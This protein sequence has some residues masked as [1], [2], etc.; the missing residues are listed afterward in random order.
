M[1]AC[2]ALVLRSPQFEFLMGHIA[3]AAPSFHRCIVFPLCGRN[4]V[5][6]HLTQL[7]L[8]L[9]LSF[10]ELPAV[11][12]IQVFDVY[13]MIQFETTYG[14]TGHTEPFGSQKT[15]FTLQATTLAAGDLSR[16]VVVVELEQL[17]LENTERALLHA[18]AL[19]VLVPPKDSV[20]SHHT[21]ARW[22]AVERALIAR[23]VKIPV[24]FA[25][26]NPLLQELYRDIEASVASTSSKNVA[27]WLYSDTYNLAVT[28]PGEV[29]P[30]LT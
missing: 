1:P 17:D 10:L 6:F 25:H 28:A 3:Q 7:V 14:A 4:T 11:S 23:E 20:L 9:V 19:L 18:S 2:S 12:P 15:G 30:P 27:H 24:Y 16:S 5:V 26:R 29:G 8:I 21:S 22:G 13:R